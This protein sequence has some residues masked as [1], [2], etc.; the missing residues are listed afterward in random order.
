MRTRRVSRPIPVAVVLVAATLDTGC[1]TT[2][3]GELRL[4]VDVQDADSGGQ[5]VCG[6]G[7]AEIVEGMPGSPAE[8][9]GLETGDWGYSVGDE[10]VDNAAHLRELLATVEPGTTVQVTVLRWRTVIDPVDIVN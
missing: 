4:G 10:F 2:T 3:V 1:A 9:A 8:H 6:N 7:G 5:G